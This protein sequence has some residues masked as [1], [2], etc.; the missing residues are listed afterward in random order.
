MKCFYLLEVIYFIYDDYINRALNNLAPEF[1][2]S[3]F[4]PF[5]FRFKLII[6]HLETG[7][8]KPWLNFHPR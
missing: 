4:F 3:I 5:S 8:A 6:Y 1:N 2:F 7:E